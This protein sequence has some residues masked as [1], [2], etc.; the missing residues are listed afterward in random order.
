MCFAVDKDSSAC[1][2]S[3]RASPYRSFQIGLWGSDE[4]QQAPA[5]QIER[6]LSGPCCL[7]SCAPGQVGGHGF[8]GKMGV[9][10]EF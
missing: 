9:L 8:V 3:L 7:A 6:G 10:W 2:V 5:L 1:C 4:D